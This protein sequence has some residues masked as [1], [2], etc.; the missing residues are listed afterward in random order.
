M[1]TAA[2]RAFPGTPVQGS[3]EQVFKLYHFSCADSGLTVLADDVGELFDASPDGKRIL[4]ERRSAPEVSTTAPAT[5]EPSTQ[6]LRHDLCVMNANGSDPHVLRSLDEYVGDP[7][8]PMW[9]AWHGDDQITFIDSAD[10]ARPVKLDEHQRKV[11]D[12]MQY[13]LTEKGTLEVLQALSGDWKEE[14]KPYFH[15]DDAGK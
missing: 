7:K 12:V 4:Y 8:P 13:R 5:T 6:P 3:P 2:P 1:F 15:A 14:I 11:V 10:N 9:P